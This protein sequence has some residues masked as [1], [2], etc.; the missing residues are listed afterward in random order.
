M[1]KDAGLMNIMSLLSES[2]RVLLGLKN[3][4]KWRYHQNNAFMRSIKN[5]IQKI[6]L[7]EGILGL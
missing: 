6:G 2:H 4:P 1:P 5:T 7:N 3:Q